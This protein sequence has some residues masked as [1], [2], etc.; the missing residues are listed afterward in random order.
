MFSY[1][2]PGTPEGS[3]YGMVTD[4]FVLVVDGDAGIE[5]AMQ[6]WE[7]LSADGAELEDA[8]MIAARHGMRR[9]PDFAIVELVDAETGSVTIAVRGRGRASLG[10]SPDRYYSG[11]GAGT[12]I[13]ASAQNIGEMTVGLR[14]ETP[15]PDRLPLGRG[16]VRTDQVHW[17]VPLPSPRPPVEDTTDPGVPSWAEGITVGGDAPAAT[18]ETFALDL[19]DEETVLGSLR[20]RRS[21]APPE[22]ET[23]LGRRRETRSAAFALVFDTGRVIRLDGQ[24]VLVGRAPHGGA[25]SNARWESLPSPSKEVS[26]THAELRV[27]GGVLVVTDL[28]ST[29]GT[30]IAPREAEPFVLRDNASAHLAT[31][32]RIDFGDGNAAVFGPAPAR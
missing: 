31:G 7:A 16:M 3:G 27:A 23:I 14:G 13:E 29:N 26:G 19:S 32:D 10:S 6:L 9:V 11:K 17:G 20:R 25:G 12:W 2:V 18:H 30:V 1:T 22:D 28:G 24:T 21:P 5:T 4:R 15:G 8:L